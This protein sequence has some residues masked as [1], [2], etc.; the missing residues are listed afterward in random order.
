MLPSLDG[1]KAFNLQGKGWEENE[2]E[3]LECHCSTLGNPRTCRMLGNTAERQTC[4]NFQKEKA[5]VYKYLLWEKIYKY[6]MP[7]KF[8]IAAF[9][10]R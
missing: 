6:R 8:D 3:L 4:S 7:F 1:S 2:S 10:D 5:Y 9:K